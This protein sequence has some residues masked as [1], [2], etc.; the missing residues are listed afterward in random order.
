MSED[1]PG[2]SLREA[3]EAKG[4]SMSDVASSTHIKVQIIEDLE[5]ND[6]SRI[7]APIYGKGF[8]KL[9][10]EFLGLE[11]QP[12]LDAYL[13]RMASGGSS[14]RRSKKPKP[15]SSPPPPPEETSAGTAPGQGSDQ[16]APGSHYVVDP[17]PRELPL[18]FHSPEPAP[19]DDDDRPQKAD[20]RSFANQVAEAISSTKDEPDEPEPEEDFFALEDPVIAEDPGAVEDEE[21]FPGDLVEED[22]GAEPVEVDEWSPSAAGTPDEDVAPE[23][24]AEEKDVPKTPREQAAEH[25]RNYAAVVVSVCVIVVILIFGINSVVHSRQ[26]QSDQDA[27]RPDA[28][29]KVSADPPEPYLD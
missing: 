11:P 23:E 25:K 26:A 3:R 1:L 15:A 9:Y 16:A 14:P 7:A 24:A 2:S 20:P 5:E 6:F 21:F 22:S 12:L 13:K 27:N 18:D 10:A 8:I 19:A 17:G 28:P 29:L 4:L